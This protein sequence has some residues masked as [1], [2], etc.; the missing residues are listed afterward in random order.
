METDKE[1]W[2]AMKFVKFLYLIKHHAMKTYGGVMLQ[3][4]AFPPSPKCG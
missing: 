1:K 2:I 4:Q 3:L